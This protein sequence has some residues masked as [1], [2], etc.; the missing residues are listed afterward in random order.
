MIKGIHG[1]LRRTTVPT[2]FCPSTASPPTTLFLPLLDRL[3]LASSP[4]SYVVKP[5][6]SHMGRFPST[7]LTKCCLSIWRRW[8]ESNPPKSDRQSGAL[9][10]GLQRHVGIA[11]GNRTRLR[12]LKAYWPNPEVQRD[13]IWWSLK[14]LNLT[15]SH[16][17][18]L[19]QRIYSPP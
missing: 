12:K 9:P 4:T 18:I 17:T 13:I 6:Q 16:P 19:W 15:A 10:R 11:Y 5:T 14:E 7:H 2:S 8:R 3:T 1:A